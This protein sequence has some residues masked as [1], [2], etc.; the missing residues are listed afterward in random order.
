MDAIVPN[1]MSFTDWM[2]LVGRVRTKAYNDGCRDGIAAMAWTRRALIQSA[3]FTLGLTVG[4]PI[5]MLC[6][7]WFMVWSTRA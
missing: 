4:I 3:G 1:K 5:G 7:F 6:M 2:E